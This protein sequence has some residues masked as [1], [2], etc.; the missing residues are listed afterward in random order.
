MKRN[1][2]VIDEE[3]CNG[4]GVCASAC[5][6]GAIQMIDGKARLVSESYCDGLGA[7]LP[8]CPTGAITMEER[9]AAAFDETAVA[10]HM[11][12]KTA[13]APAPVQHIHGGGCPGSRLRT[14]DAPAAPK[15]EEPAAG[16]R[17]SA[18]RQ[19]PCQIRL[20]PVNA[21]YLQGANLLIAADCTAF[22]NANVHSRWMRNR[23]TL[24]GCPKL[25]D[26]DYSE[27][28]ADIFRQ[29]DI[30]SLT[31]LRMSVPCCGGIAQAVKRA[32]ADAGVMIPWQIVTIDVNGD[33]LE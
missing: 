1:I 27:K 26:V 31:I 32:M 20:V 4:C 8:H 24:I 16:E 9:E 5:H 3:K 2:I 15:A 18:L 33:V 25:D 22:A 6:E 12:T 29:N 11:T 17:P 14:F 19:W 13:P 23:I 10:Q 30:Q 7:C 21:P 28:L